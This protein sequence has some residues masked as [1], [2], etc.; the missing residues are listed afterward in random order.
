MRVKA[1]I[2]EPQRELLWAT[3]Q[4]R[5]ELVLAITALEWIAAEVHNASQA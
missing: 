2:D 5:D 4:Y 3:I 1:F